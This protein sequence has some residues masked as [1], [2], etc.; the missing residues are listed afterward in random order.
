MPI[1]RL[2][3][4]NFKGVD[5]RQQFTIK[6]I[7]L[8]V[9]ANSSGK[10]S[11]LHAL[12]CLAQT[13]KIPNNT[14]P[15][16]LDDDSAHVHLGRFIEVIHSKSYQDEITLGVQVSP[17]GQ[18]ASRFRKI[19][20][21]HPIYAE[22]SFKCALRTQDIRLERGVVSIGVNRRAIRTTFRRPF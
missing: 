21:N 5:K 14:E 20:G 15:I 8:F 19:V 12:A 2:T 22:W 16:V 13:V 10:S 11:C 17:G 6:P 18:V 4:A 3:I 1:T 9:G 7:T